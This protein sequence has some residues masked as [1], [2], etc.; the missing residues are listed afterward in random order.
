MRDSEEE[1]GRRVT[2]VLVDE[3]T[4]QA[5]I[6]SH[7]LTVIG[8]SPARDIID[9]SWTDT[10]QGITLKKLANEIGGKFKIDC[11]TFPRE[12]DTTHIVPVFSLSGESP[13][14]KLVNEAHNQGLMFTASE[15]GDLY[16]WKAGRGN[17]E[18]F[19]LTEGVNI[20]SIRWTD[21][22][23]EQFHEY[24]LTGGGKEA[25][26]IDSTCNTNRVLTIAMT[27]PTIDQA[28]LER[29]ARTEMRRR[30]EN[31]TKV[32]VSGW[33]LTSEQ[34]KRLWP[35]TKEKEVFWVP[36]MLIPLKVPSI[37]LNDRLLIS[38]VEYEANV[39][40]FGCTITVVNIEAYL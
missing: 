12:S 23:S 10:Y 18:Q 36:N 30:R 35:T 40:T 17:P 7:G 28:R 11:H 5:D 37:G 29:R 39:D 3:I 6:Q 34:I 13:W 20:K 21:N 26:I 22:G 9:S 33:G 8:R 15:S 14:A 2:T 27:D 16:L 1:G 19:Y 4:A 38:E 24:I 32:T 31:R 25:R